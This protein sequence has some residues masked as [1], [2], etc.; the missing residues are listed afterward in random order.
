MR[1]IFWSQITINIFKKTPNKLLWASSLVAHYYLRSTCT[2]LRNS[3][4][5]SAL[6]STFLS[7]QHF[8]TPRR[9]RAAPVFPGE[10]EIPIFQK[11][12]NIVKHPWC[13]FYEF[14]KSVPEISRELPSFPVSTALKPFLLRPIVFLWS[15]P[16]MIIKRRWVEGE[17]E[18]TTLTKYYRLDR[19]GVRSGEGRKWKMVCGACYLPKDNK[20]K[21]LGEDAHFI[22]KEKQAVGV[23][24]G[25]GGW[26]AKGVD[27]GE[28]ARELMNNAEIAIHQEPNGHMDLKG[29]LNKAFLNTKPEGSSTACLAV[30]EDLHLKAINVGDSGFLVF[31]NKALMYRSPIQQHEFNTP[32]QLG[33]SKTCDLPCSA[34]RIAV[35]VLPEDI[36]VFGTDGLLDNMYPR[37][38]ED[39]LKRGT[40]EEVN[41]EELAST[42]AEFALY[43]SLDKYRCSP[44]ARA[45]HLEGKQHI[46]GKI[47]DITVIV[48]HIVADNCEN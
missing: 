39:I 36:I 4:I 11:H 21:P 41:P 27:A 38:I 32:Y 5:G 47:D 6:E 15:D 24:D 33:T 18:V 35:A 30:L 2:H 48:G 34:M 17:L 1:D 44:F 23:A 10:W 40:S 43:N 8:H 22:C 20:L 29:V 46:G 25:V 45:A 3:H 31:R 9:Q 13:S 42:I 12:I 16:E 7:K 37:E 14:P 28:Y 19:E 26:A